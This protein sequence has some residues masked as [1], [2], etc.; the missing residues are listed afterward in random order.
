MLYNKLN[1]KYFIIFLLIFII[2]DFYEKFY[3]IFFIGNLKYIPIIYV[4]DI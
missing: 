4:L 3:N 2:L 1:I